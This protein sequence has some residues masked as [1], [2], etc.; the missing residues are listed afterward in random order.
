MPSPH[1]IEW[2]SLRRRDRQAPADA[3]PAPPAPMRRSLSSAAPLHLPPKA[4]GETPAIRVV[5]NRQSR[6][7]RCSLRRSPRPQA[8]VRRDTALCFLERVGYI[9]ADKACQ[10]QKRPAGIV[11]Q[12]SERSRADERR[13]AIRAWPHCI[14]MSRYRSS[15]DECARAEAGRRRTMRRS[16]LRRRDTGGLLGAAMVWSASTQRD[17]NE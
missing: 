11:S 7:Q 9:E 4:L 1:P 15:A 6:K 3:M 16:R 5:A 14:M 10:P 13:I 17:D 2:R 8:T 12:F